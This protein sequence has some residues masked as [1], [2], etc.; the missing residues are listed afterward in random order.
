MQKETKIRLTVFITAALLV[1]GWGWWSNA[2]TLSATQPAAW[3]AKYDNERALYDLTETVSSL[4][5]ALEKARYASTPP[6]QSALLCQL[7]SSSSSAR[8]ALSCLE[9]G[10]EST[11]SVSKFLS[12]T[13]DYSMVLLRR[14][15]MGETLSEEETA[16]LSSLAS[17]SQK[18]QNALQNLSSDFD[19]GLVHLSDELPDLSEESTLFADALDQAAEMFT[20]YPTLLYDGPFSDHIAQEEPACLSQYETVTASQAMQTAKDLPFSENYDWQAGSDEEGNLPCYTFQ[21]G[22]STLRLTCAGGLLLS[23]SDPRPVEEENLSSQEAMEK[24]GAT[25]QSLGFS[26]MQSAYSY[27]ADG[28]CVCLFFYEQDNVICYPDLVKVGIAL[29]DGSVVRVEATGYRMNHVARDLA[30][31]ALSS[32]QAQQSLSS[33]LTVL[34]APSLTLIPSPGGSEL[35]CW[36]FH[37]QGQE[38]EELLVYINAQTGY[39]EQMYELLYSDAGTLTR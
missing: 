13:E 11:A 7:I 9:T 28:V 5:T 33:Q 21:S 25:L 16:S 2:N 36:E 8:Q 17:Y 12:Q 29:D 10:E 6:M 32:S 15:S 22:E 26:D 27:T 18:L 4:T 34:Q 39:E 23:F 24:A 37:C 3:Q 20:G 1:T 30:S 14:L 38:E 31:P 35:L 19:N